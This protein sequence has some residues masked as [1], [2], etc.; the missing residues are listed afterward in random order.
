MNSS[1][2]NTWD[3]LKDMV[4]DKKKWGLLV[5]EIKDIIQMKTV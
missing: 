3:E 4:K 1:N 2:A 5:R